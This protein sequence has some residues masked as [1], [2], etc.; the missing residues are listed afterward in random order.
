MVCGGED[1]VRVPEPKPCVAGDV[2]EVDIR[3]QKLRLDVR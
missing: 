1:L 3:A 2:L